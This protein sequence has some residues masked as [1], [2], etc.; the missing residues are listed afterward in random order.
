MAN[1]KRKETLNIA[2]QLDEARPYKAGDTITGRVVC[3]SHVVSPRAWFTVQLAGTTKVIIRTDDGDGGTRHYRSSHE[4][5]TQPVIQTLFD[6]PI[7]IPPNP[8]P[9]Q[10]ES[11]L[12]SLTIPYQCSPPSEAPRQSTASTLSPKNHTEATEPQPPPYSP[13]CLPLPPSFSTT[14]TDIWSVTTHAS[15]SYHITARF[16]EQHSTH[17]QTTA[18]TLPINI[19]PSTAPPLAEPQR[20]HTQNSRHTVYS[21]RLLGQETLSLWDCFSKAIHAPWIPQYEFQ[22]S[23]SC[24]AELQPGA[25]RPFSFQV[26]ITPLRQSESLGPLEK[27]N[28]EVKL[29]RL[30]LRL[31]AWT[32]VTCLEMGL[33][34]FKRVE[35]RC[36]VEVVWEMEG[37]LGLPYA[38]EDAAWDAGRAMGL[39]FGSSEIVYCDEMEERERRTEAVRLPY[40]SCLHGDFI[41]ANMRHLHNLEWEIKLAVAGETVNVRGSRRVV[42]VDPSTVPL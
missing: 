39:R 3:K 28:P 27:T 32:D 29:E 25:H 26:V 38:P 13:P 1:V 14:T 41:M 31:V 34:G 19:V 9:E 18:T 17:T 2:I 33:V 5:I 36:V 23:V 35:E 15:V 12:F 7:H 42:V 30:V 4:L 22:V 10:F 21:Q 11:R 20:L 40:S 24:P 16:H 8:T 6:G 37:G